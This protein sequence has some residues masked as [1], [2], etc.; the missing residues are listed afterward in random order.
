MPSRTALPRSAA[1]TKPRLR[2]LVSAASVRRPHSCPTQTSGASQVKFGGSPRPPVRFEVP[3]R[4]RKRRALPCAAFGSPGRGAGS[5][6]PTLPTLPA[7]QAPFRAKAAWIQHHQQQ[8][9]RFGSSPRPCPFALR[10]FGR[11]LQA[12]KPTG[13]AWRN[14]RNYRHATPKRG[15]RTGELERMLAEQSHLPGKWEAANAILQLIQY[16]N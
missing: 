4:M 11:R 10:G 8:P 6:C 14:L 2:V 13:H 1:L 16:Y 12:V 3:A 5:V 9:E 15:P 7:W